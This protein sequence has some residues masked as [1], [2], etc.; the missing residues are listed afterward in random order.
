MT[1]K[2]GRGVFTTKFLKRG[3]LIAVE[4]TIAEAN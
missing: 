3:D 2:K 1:K 4:K